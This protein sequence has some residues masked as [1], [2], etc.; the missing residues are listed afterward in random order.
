[1]LLSVLLLAVPAVRADYSPEQFKA[2]VKLFED[3]KQSHK[4][5]DLLEFFRKRLVS[6]KDQMR[7]EELIKQLSSPS[8]KERE[9]AVADLIELGPPAL[10]S[11]RKVMQSGVELE[12]AKR[13]DKA[14]KEI[15]KRSPNTLVMAAARLLKAR[16][17][18]GAVAVLLEYVPVAPDDVVEE[19]LLICIYELAL[20]GAKLEMFPPE[21]KAGK[22]DAL[23][24]QALADK[25]PARRAIAALT[26]ACFG[27]EAQRQQVQKLLA[28]ADPHVRFRA[29]QGLL[30]KQDKKAVPVLVELLHKG[31]MNL[32]L[33]AEDLLS[34]AAQ[35]K[36]PAVPLSEKE[37]ARAKCHEA[38][39]TWWDK[40]QNTLDLAKVRFDS[41]FGG[42]NARASAAS[43]AFIQAIIKFDIELVRKATDVPFT[44]GGIITFNTREEFDNFLNQNK[45][46]GPDNIKFKVEKIISAAEYMKTAPEQERVFLEAARPAQVHIVYIQIIDGPG[47]GGPQQTLP[48]FI[49]ISGGRAKCIG[50]SIGR[51]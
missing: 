36:G 20:S 41:P 27:T 10:P 44:I 43:V 13:C 9:K 51:G 42:I 5:A 33:Q 8:F 45:G 46:G 40:N 2:D 19:E 37:A 38:W 32:A 47:G 31:P 11:L 48:L 3:A 35:E 14:V 17:A 26:V 21:V 22:L 28:D 39:Q 16:Q 18:P 23:L 4:D 7:A 25:E 1:L 12:I 34:L 6:P 30:T 50:L 49:R 15:E 24:V 29:A